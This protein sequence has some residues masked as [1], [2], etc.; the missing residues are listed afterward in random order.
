MYSKTKLK[1][2]HTRT[3]AH[4]QPFF[5]FRSPLENE[6]R[7][8]KWYIKIKSVLRWKVQSIAMLWHLELDI[9]LYNMFNIKLEI[10]L[11]AALTQEHSKSVIIC[12]F[13][14]IQFGCNTAHGKYG[15]SLSWSRT[16][17][18]KYFN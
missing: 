18:T 4:T 15:F 3:H 5:F 9:F 11:L 8:N 1:R 12:F 2:V 7:S 13:V 10:Q 6:L 16:L 17:D 14:A